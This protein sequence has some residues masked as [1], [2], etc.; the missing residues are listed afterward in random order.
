MD[1]DIRAAQESDLQMLAETLRPE[2]AHELLAATGSEDHLDNIRRSIEASS[3]VLVGVGHGEPPGCIFGIVEVTEKTALI[4]A[5]A[6]PGIN[7]YRVPFMRESLYTLWRWFKERP[8]LEH[9]VNFVHADNQEHHK[10]LRWAG[11]ELHPAV[12][13]GVLG[14]QFHPFRIHRSRY[15]V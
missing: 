6:T 13:Y 3:E 5:V 10:W 12:P 2:D 9:M 7:K 1:Y 15:N 4:W 11:A 8:Q 14:E